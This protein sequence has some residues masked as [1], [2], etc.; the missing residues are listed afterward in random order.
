MT[1]PRSFRTPAAFRSWLEKHHA[2]VSELMLRCYKIHAAQRGITYR[3]G[4]DEAL[5]F[6]WIDGVRRRLDEDSFTVRFTPRKPRSTWSNVNVARV[7]VLI[8][9]GRMAGPGLA[10]FEAREERLTGI[11]SFERASA[12]LTAA[13]ARTFRANRA[14]WT[15]FTAQ[16]PWYQRTCIFWVMSAKREATR[17]KRLDLL[18]ARSADGARIPP[19]DRGP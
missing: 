17:A 19:L 3:Q 6:G 13:H 16:A 14:A 5:C 12:T 8:A 2:R 11:Y 4:L 15:Y 1:L 18:M 10:A 9:E 7:R